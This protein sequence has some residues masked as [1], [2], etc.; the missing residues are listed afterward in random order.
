MFQSFPEHC[1]DLL[2]GIR[3]RVLFI[4]VIATMK[5]SNTVWLFFTF[6]RLSV[7]RVILR[8]GFKVKAMDVILSPIR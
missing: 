4:T 8:R 1:P 5:T 3:V 7:R 6:L 2:G